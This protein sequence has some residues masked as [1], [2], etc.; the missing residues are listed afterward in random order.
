MEYDCLV[1]ILL[2]QDT[3]E[4]N[5]NHWHLIPPFI[6]DSAAIGLRLPLKLDVVHSSLLS[7]SF[8]DNL[9]LYPHF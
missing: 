7:R 5:D 1:A 9:T 3:T 2:Q 8:S 6:Y 4:E